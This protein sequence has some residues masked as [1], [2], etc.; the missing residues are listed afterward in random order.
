[1]WL[2]IFDLNPVRESV[3]LSVKLYSPKISFDLLFS[4]SKFK[5]PEYPELSVPYNS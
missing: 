3:K 4:G 2:N 5:L 1:M